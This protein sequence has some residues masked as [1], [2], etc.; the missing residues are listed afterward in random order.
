MDFDR[1]DFLRIGAAVTAG[2]AIGPV[3]SAMTQVEKEGSTARRWGMVID[4]DKCSADCTV[5]VDAC[6]TENN[7][8]RF[9][10]PKLDIHWIRKIAFRPKGIEGATERT[11][12]A[13]CFHC[14]HPPCAHVCPVAA[15][16]VRPDGIVQVDKHR[17]IG[18]R[19]CVIACPY[20]ARSFVAKHVEPKEGDNP[21]VPSRTHGVVEKCT[22]CA[23]RIDQGM[24]PACVEACQKKATGAM[25]FSD[26][27]NPDTDASALLRTGRARQL[28]ADL[29]CEPGVYYMGL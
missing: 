2:A 17:C 15:T 8:P 21:K 13:M 24:Q 18:C 23:H 5:C 16:F 10:D 6:R 7:V 1:R 26:L 3:A 19:Y 25:V 22:L 20:K 11:F 29:G 27:N 4:A 9:D 12:P 14:E 28:R